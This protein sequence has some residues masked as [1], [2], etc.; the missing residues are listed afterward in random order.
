MT[1]L[2]FGDDDDK[3]L[4]Q[5]LHSDD[6]TEIFVFEQDYIHNPRA[7]WLLVCGDGI[8]MEDLAYY[9]DDDRRIQIAL[10]ADVGEDGVY[11]KNNPQDEEPSIRHL[12]SFCR[13]MH[14]AMKTYLQTGTKCDAKTLQ[15]LQICARCKNDI[16]EDVADIYTYQITNWDL[17]DGYLN[18]LDFVDDWKDVFGSDLI[19]RIDKGNGDLGR[20]R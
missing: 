15:S 6:G 20:D 18:C 4:Y 16:K 3:R 8:K 10:L 12:G 9:D 5:V 2:L 19:P 17:D 14:E 13:Q 1:T 7:E 11:N